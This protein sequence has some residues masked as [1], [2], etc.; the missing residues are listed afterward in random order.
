MPAATVEELLVSGQ[1][2]VASRRLIV[3]NDFSTTGLPWIDRS[4]AGAA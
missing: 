3:E 4:E 2:I 1:P